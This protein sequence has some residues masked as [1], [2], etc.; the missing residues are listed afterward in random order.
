MDTPSILWTD[1]MRHVLAELQQ[2]SLLHRLLAFAEQRG[3]KLYAVGGTLRDICLGR[4]AQDMDLALA[5]DVIGFARGFANHLQAAFVPMDT[6]RGE[7][8]VVYRGRDVIDFAQFKGATILED[9]RHRDFTINAMACPLD[10]LL[11]HAA[12]DLIDPH[13][14]WHDL[15]AHVIR[16]VSPMS[17]HEDPL[18]LLRAF[19]LAASFDFAID[20]STL[21]AMELV[22]PRLAEVAAER[23][24]SELLKLFAALHSHVYIVT[25]ARLGLLDVLFP[26]L[27]ATHGMGQQLG[28]RLDAFDHALQTYQ[29]V[30]ELINA[31]ASHLPTMADAVIEYFQA[32][33]RRA[34]VKWAALLHAVGD[35]PAHPEVTQ[36]Q[37][38]DH[39]DPEQSAQQWEQIGS[40]LKLSRRQIDYI[41][42]LIAHHYRPIT[43][44]GLQAQGRLTLRLVHHWCK[45]V[46]DDMLGV[47]LLAIGHVLAKGQVDTPVHGALAIGQCAM[48]ILDLYR[49]RVLPVLKAPRLV[50]GHDLRHIFN[51]SPGPRFKT[52]L[53]ELEVARV[54]GRIH[55][56]TAALQWVEE[57]L[58]M[59]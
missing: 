46:G 47:F 24:H 21:A 23:I 42:M 7:A 55:T 27:G 28:D 54:E 13:G 49:R 18:R 50:T 9:L 25:M 40:R 33:E 1:P 56:R 5:G 59:S 16:M 58:T 19:R 53:D 26:E 43:L 2:R 15:E 14:G 52:L 30:E 22:A 57:Q 34:L 36:E 8:R 45:E 35:A 6:E 12:P 44:A 17:F 4:P 51:L 3:M 37:V 20:P 32:E 39:R 48:H 29:S 31:P 38:A 10:A 11:T 41:K